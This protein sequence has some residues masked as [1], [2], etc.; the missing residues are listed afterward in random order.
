MRRALVVL[1]S[2]TVLASGCATARTAN[3]RFTQQPTAPGFDRALL[4][5][6]LKQLPVG[7]RVRASLASGRTLRG[8]LMKATNEGIVVQRRTRIPEPP[9]D[10]PIEDVRAV[11]IDTS[12]GG[13]G[14]AVAI[15]AAAGAGASLGV[16]LLLAAI[17][18]GD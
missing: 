9:I 8:T 4:T 14:R 6:Y 16:L 11:E 10:I 2:I 3:S 17:F 1:L 15:G 13:V 7:S 5:A 18:S 12:G